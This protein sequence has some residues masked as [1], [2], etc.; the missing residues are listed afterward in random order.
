MKA[1]VRIL[2]LTAVV[3]FGTACEPLDWD[4]D[5]GGGS[6]G[7]GAFSSGFVFVRGDTASGRDVYVVDDD[8]DP[9]LP[10]RLTTQGGAS[11][12]TVARSGLLV[13]YVYRSGSTWELR[14][15]P[16]TGQGTPSTVVSSQSCAPCNNF[17]APVFSP[18]GSEIAFTLTRNGVSSVARVNTDGSGFQLLLQG[19]YNVHGAASYYPD[20]Q[21]LLVTAGTSANQMTTL[22]VVNLSTGVANTLTSSLGNAGAFTVVSRAVVSPDGTRVAFDAQTS[23]GAQIFVGQLG[24]GLSGVTQLTRHTGESGVVDSWPSWRGNTEVTFQSSAGGS[25][26]LY[27]VSTAS[28]G[29]GTLVVPRVLEPAYGGR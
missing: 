12:P 16:T 21:R 1:W 25:D 15:V 2:G 14:T 28:P 5:G 6:G 20:G 26:N 19:T 24:Q 18:S 17:Q 4:G 29:A 7:G 11:A 3:G 23:N 13:A 8:G 22:R 10:V 9:N 27:R